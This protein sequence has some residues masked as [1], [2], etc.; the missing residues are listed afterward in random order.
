MCR[1]E[2]ARSCLT[3]GNTD[4]SRSNRAGARSEPH[5]MERMHLG[6]SLPRSFGGPIAAHFGKSASRPGVAIA[7]AVITRND[8]AAW[9]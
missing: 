4:P 3:Q 8:E 6:E 9:E 5:V 1:H 2:G 7:I